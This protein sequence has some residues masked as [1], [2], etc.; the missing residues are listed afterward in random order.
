MPAVSH[1]DHARLAARLGMGLAASAV[2]S[3]GQGCQ[4]CG[5]AEGHQR[6]HCPQLP[7][8]HAEPLRALLITRMPTAQTYDTVIQA[9]GSLT[10]QGPPASG[11][12]PRSRPAV[13]PRRD[14]PA[15]AGPSAVQNPP[16]NPPR[17]ARAPSARAPLRR[18]AP[19]PSPPAPFPHPTARRETPGPEARG[20]SRQGASRRRPDGRDIDGRQRGAGE[21]GLRP[22]P[23]RHGTPPEGQPRSGAIHGYALAPQGPSGPGGEHGYAWR[24]P[25]GPQ[26]S[27][28]GGASPKP[29]AH[30]TRCRAAE[31]A[32]SGGAARR[33][34]AAI[35]LLRH[36][37]SPSPTAATWSKAPPGQQGPTGQPAGPAWPRPKRPNCH[38]LYYRRAGGPTGRERRV[39][40]S[41]LL[42]TPAARARAGTGRSAGPIPRP[43]PSP[44]APWHGQW[45]PRR[46]GRAE[47]EAGGR[48]R[49]AP[50]GPAQ[51]NRTGRMRPAHAERPSKQAAR[52]GP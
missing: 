1:D 18:Q 7:P 27:G 10:G 33:P 39:T 50:A 26:R 3:G 28:R 34:A 40:A 31:H 36:R 37:P 13:R 42:R 20:P 38:T 49:T 29:P 9:G 19:A 11:A 46:P 35:P 52:A 21:G 25:P 14:P 51:T 12:G 2:P 5:G 22:G 47:A 45:G 23:R 30:P 6:R 43:A 32:Q 44:T 15:R 4:P 48:D 41:A 16:P 8:S 24:R 17:Q